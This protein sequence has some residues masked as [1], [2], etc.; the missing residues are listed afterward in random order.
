MLYS[1]I[2][3]RRKITSL[4]P[5]LLTD[6][7]A[8]RLTDPQATPKTNPLNHLTGEHALNQQYW[9]WCPV[10]QRIVDWNRFT[11]LLTQSLIGAGSL[12][13]GHPLTRSPSVIDRVTH[14]LTVSYAGSLN[15]DLG[16][17]G[18]RQIDSYL[19]ILT[20]FPVKYFPI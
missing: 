20:T 9:C 18:F 10:S 1:R 5:T 15:H 7:L 17:T 6:W 11:S 2:D 4:L 14:W 3:S 8:R 16:T 13:L 19:H 12:W